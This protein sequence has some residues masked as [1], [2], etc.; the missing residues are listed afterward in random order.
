MTT[1]GTSSSNDAHGAKG[2]SWS[3]THFRVDRRSPSSCWV[4]FSDLERDL[5]RRV[6]EALADA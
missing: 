5:G 1:T 2:R 4:T 3:W 6:L